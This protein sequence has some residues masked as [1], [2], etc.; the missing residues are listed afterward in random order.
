MAAELDACD[1][2]VGSINRHFSKWKVTWLKQYVKD[3]D[4]SCAKHKKSVLIGS[5]H[6]FTPLSN[7]NDALL[8][9]SLKH[10]VAPIPAKYC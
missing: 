10:T 1:S 5:A 9:K 7:N 2:V 3:P 8:H 6:Y 4:I